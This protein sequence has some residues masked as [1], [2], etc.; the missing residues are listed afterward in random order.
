MSVLNGALKWIKN[1]QFAIQEKVWG[2]IKYISTQE[3]LQKQT[4]FGQTH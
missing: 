3:A 2:Y 1:I 4:V